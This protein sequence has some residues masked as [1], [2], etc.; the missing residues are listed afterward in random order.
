MDNIPPQQSPQNQ[1]YYPGDEQRPPQYYGQD[2]NGN[3]QYGQNNYRPNQNYQNNL[4]N[5]PNRPNGPNIYGN[6]QNG[7]NN[8]YPNYGQN[9]NYVQNPNNGQYP[10]GG[11]V[12]SNPGQPGVMTVNP[13]RPSV[14]Q[15]PNGRPQQ[16]PYN[17]YGNG[18]GR[19][20]A[21]DQCAAQNSLL[22]DPQTRCCGRDMSNTKKITGKTTHIIVVTHS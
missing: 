13:G 21:R 11:N 10:N 18:F 8:P 2:N 1:N 9:P 3:P 16:N 5:Q 7:A 15:N 12:W 17:N 20:P 22:P 6:G 4:Q 19:Q 14:W